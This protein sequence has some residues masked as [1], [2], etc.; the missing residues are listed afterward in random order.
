MG[1][2]EEAPGRRRLRRS[3]DKDLGRER[4]AQI[5]ITH[6]GQ[7]L[8]HSGVRRKDHRLGRHQA[9]GGHVVIAHEPPHRGGLVR[10]HQL[11]QP[12]LVS[13][14]HLAQQIGSIVVVHCFEDV[15]GPLVAEGRQ[16]ADLIVF[17]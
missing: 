13:R 11:Q 10:F 5:G 7:G 4:R 1:R 3:N 16:Q 12:L 9:A 15:G 17:G 14:G 2:A 6:E 8:G